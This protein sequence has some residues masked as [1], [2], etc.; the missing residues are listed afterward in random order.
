MLL[1]EDDTA[2]AEVL[3]TT[4][5]VGVETYAEDVVVS[6]ELLVVD[7]VTYDAVVVLDVDVDGE[8]GW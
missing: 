5:V 1:T 8:F 7:A 6:T 3:D 2:A 4:V